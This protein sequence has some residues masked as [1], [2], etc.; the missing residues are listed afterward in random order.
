MSRK[1]YLINGSTTLVSGA[2][3]MYNEILQKR[4]QNHE[5]IWHPL[6]GQ[7]SDIAAGAIYT[8]LFLM[9]NHYKEQK[10]NTKFFDWT[11]PAAAGTLCTFGELT[12]IMGDTFDPK[13]IAAYWLGAGIAYVIHRALATNTLEAKI[14]PKNL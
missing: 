13:D 12:G 10:Y 11:A 7:G 1:P 6:M 2:L 5:A 3:G 9:C 4:V 14:Q 8:A